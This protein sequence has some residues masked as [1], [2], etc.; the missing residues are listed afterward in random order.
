MPMGHADA[1]PFAAAAASMRARHVGGGP[2]FVDEDEPLRIEIELAL[3]PGL[4]P[5][6]DIRPVLFAGVRGLFLRVMA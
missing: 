4:A 3:K 2:G 1:Q 5:L 6:Q